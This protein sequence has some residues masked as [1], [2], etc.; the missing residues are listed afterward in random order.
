MNVYVHNLDGCTAI[1]LSSYLKSLGVL[2]LITEQGK[3]ENARGWWDRWGFR[4]M[5]RLS[6][7]DLE[8]FFVE[9]YRPTPIFSPWNRGSGFYYEND[10]AVQALMASKNARLMELRQA[11]CESK[12]MVQKLIEVDAVIRSIKDCTKTGRAFQSEVQRQ[13]LSNSPI[14]AEQKAYWQQQGRADE[15]EL[16]DELVSDRPAPNKRRADQ[17][18]GA[19][20]YK[21]LLEAAEKEFGRL[22]EDLIPACFRGWR[23]QAIKWLRAAVVLQDSGEAFYPALFGSGGNDGRLDF[24]YNFLQRVLWLTSQEPG[25]SEEAR[26]LL[27]SALFGKHSHRLIDA[28][29]GMYNPVY[30]GGANC[31]TGA[32]GEAKINPW[33]FVLALEGALLLRPSVTR[34]LLSG[35]GVA[36]APF[37]VTSEGIGYASAGDENARAE[38]WMPLWSAPSLLGEVE[39]FLAEGRLQAGRRTAGQ[40]LEVAQAI[41]RL[42]VTRGVSHF[43][44]YG[45]LERNGQSTLAVPLGRFEVRSSVRAR[46]ADDLMGWIERLRR[47]R[48]NN[49]PIRLKTARR[50]LGNALMEAMLRD[51]GPERWIEVLKCAVEVENVQAKGAGIEAGPI[52]RL[53]PGW[54]EA[55][56]NR[57]ETRLALALAGAKCRE[58]GEGSGCLRAHWLPLESSGW[59]FKTT[60]QGQ[61]ELNPRV[62]STGADAVVDLL[63]IVHRRF[64]E[65]SMRGSRH[66][67][68]EPRWGW[69]AR[70]DDLCAWIEGRLDTELVVTLARA[71]MALNWSQISENKMLNPAESED[72]P[73]EAYLVLRLAA[74]PWE[75]WEGCDIP[76][77]EEVF[78]RLRAGRVDEAVKI[79]ARRLQAA[80][81]RP[82]LRAAALDADSARLWAASFAFPVDRLTACRMVIRMDPNQKGNENGQT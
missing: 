41:S 15:V 26:E 63:A 66:F 67:P 34:R 74:M 48:D 12:R 4:L 62:V 29:I 25:R 49:A 35:E 57:A 61:L 45:Y 36:A 6:E 10:D 3:D 31:T 11:F 80:G 24:A 27:W 59:R 56:G 64:V 19:T 8:R 5:T 79:A 54:V 78:F 51:D 43:V 72:L 18:K 9:E 69:G 13:R 1:P 17:I 75:L 33:E 32:T 65:A 30:A 21:K 82:P 47:I 23:G 53:S 81:I 60:P 7:G 2:R 70:L 37:Q 39:S 44:R 28:K 55:V 73:S 68:L 14:F 58:T 42:G 76:A 16:L 52:P 71:F 22:K 46:L 50:A 38:Q 20:A 40:P 77:E